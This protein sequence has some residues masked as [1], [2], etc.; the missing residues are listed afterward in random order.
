MASSQLQTV[1]QDSG[2]KVEQLAEGIRHMEFMVELDREG[3]GVSSGRSGP[4]HVWIE[5]LGV[6][7]F[8][9][10]IGLEAHKVHDEL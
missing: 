8:A 10:G 7:T 5:D 1:V 9:L 4:V 3:T 2:R 6:V